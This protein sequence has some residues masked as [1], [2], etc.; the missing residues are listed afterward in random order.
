[1]LSFLHTAWGAAECSTGTWKMQT[2]VLV[3]LG[4]VRKIR[5]PDRLP[6]GLP[7]ERQDLIE[8]AVDAFEVRPEPPDPRVPTEPGPLRPGVPERPAHRLPASRPRVRGAPRGGR[9]PPDSRCRTRRSPR[10]KTLTEQLADLILDAPAVEHAGDPAPDP[11]L[12]LG[13]ATSRPTITAAL[14][15]DRVRVVSTDPPPASRISS[16]RMTRRGLRWSIEA[17]P[18]GSRRRSSAVSACKTFRG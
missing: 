12:V 1:M 2:D 13:R 11:A 16:A 4:P 8:D 7:V 17:A 15:S 5:T 18:S 3:R 6:G 10:V 9:A 14:G